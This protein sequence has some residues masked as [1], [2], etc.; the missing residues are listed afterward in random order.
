MGNTVFLL[1]AEDPREGVVGFETWKD[2]HALLKLVLLK[3]E[4][5]A[6]LCVRPTTLVALLAAVSPTSDAQVQ[7]IE[8]S[9]L[10]PQQQQEAAGPELV[11]EGELPSFVKDLLETAD[12]KSDECQICFETNVEAVYFASCLHQVCR[13]CSQRLPACPFC[14]KRVVAVL[15][16]REF[17]AKY[18]PAAPVTAGIAEKDEEGDDVATA[19]A[20]DDKRK[21]IV[22]VLPDQHEAFLK[23]RCRQT[24]AAQVGRLAP[25]DE[26]FLNDVHAHSPLL[27]IQC[28]LALSE[29]KKLRSEE[30]IAFIAAKSSSS[31]SELSKLLPLYQ[32]RNGVLRLERLLAAMAGDSGKKYSAKE[33]IK[34]LVSRTEATG[35]EVEHG[36]GSS[37][38]GS[39]RKS[40]T[41]FPRFL[42]RFIMNA[43]SCI[44]EQKAMDHLRA[45][46][47]DF[48]KPILL[49]RCHPFA[50]AAKLDGP[51]KQ[52]LLT[53][54]AL[55]ARNSAQ[56][57]ERW[58]KEAAQPER[59]GAPRPQTLVLP[60]QQFSSSL[61]RFMGYLEKQDAAI[62]GFL[63]NGNHGLVA[64][65]LLLLLRTFPTY[66]H[67][68]S[69]GS[70]RAHPAF[71]PEMLRR[72]D[73]VTIMELCHCINVEMERLRDVPGDVAETESVDQIYLTSS[74]VM[75]KGKKVLPPGSEVYTR[76]LRHTL[77]LLIARTR[78]L[79]QTQKHPNLQ[80]LVLD[81]RDEALVRTMVPRG[82]QFS[83][84]T[85][86][87]HA[88]ANDSSF[89]V[90]PE[91]PLVLGTYWI[92]EDVDIDL[93]SVSLDTDFNVIGFCSYSQPRADGEV[94]H[95][96][97]VVHPDLQLGSE[98][99]SERI[100]I[101]SLAKW[102][103]STG[104]R[105]IV[106]V[107]FSFSGVP[108]DEVKECLTFFGYNDGGGD[109]P[110]KAR[111]LACR[112]LR[113]ASK[114]NISLI[115]D[116]EKN[117][118]YLCNLNVKHK[119][120]KNVEGLKK[121]G[122][123]GELVRSY[124]QYLQQRP[125]LNYSHVV[126]FLPFVYNRVL[127][128]SGPFDDPSDLYFEKKP[129]QTTE[130][131]YRSL[132]RRKNGQPL[133]KAP[134]WVR[135]VLTGGE[136]LPAQPNQQASRDPPGSLHAGVSD[137]KTAVLAATPFM[138]L[139]LRSS[140]RPHN[141]TYSH[142]DAKDK[143]GGPCMWIGNKPPQTGLPPGSI[144]ASPFITDDSLLN[145]EVL[146]CL[147][148]KEL[149]EPV[150]SKAETAPD[151]ESSSKAKTTPDKE[152]SSK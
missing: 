97:D 92:S 116:A 36:H 54:A 49:H 147:C 107:N 134:D 144:V 29:E 88:Q 102:A 152:S 132:R 48:W 66:P 8:N 150:T 74:R 105:Y 99:A 141:E 26:A 94:K 82:K 42:Q 145:V 126:S 19:R 61:G 87:G 136:K 24:I 30:V 44:P 72:W 143:G 73:I 151:K 58:S 130:S 128:R 83:V 100:W 140:S 75:H 41:A 76:L 115:V 122:L 67:W 6:Y 18:A 81:N 149:A 84:P 104:G 37:P 9:I 133:H 63:L 85:W 50:Y 59:K 28:L 20:R 12:A 101:P 79:L 142:D 114:I 31:A 34:S 64:R 14:R 7:L 32:T 138:P 95:S 27:L 106:L 21:K 65:R 111:V 39:E 57:Q 103:Q 80:L 23:Q 117:V 90:D 108:F 89:L 70:D 35:A 25:K 60:S 46:K 77:K 119:T 51:P 68:F 137:T 123:L 38:Q 1:H 78:A 98:H 125:P 53:I 131:F 2:I 86:A 40:R 16:R 55:L 96:G 11:F 148:P 62:F 10:P 118:A 135:G 5:V 91:L 129:E 113:G 15:T 110:E 47:E 121:E 93:S 112:R 146:R 139:G 3:K 124:F 71:L 33:L 45:R 17:V 4:H 120:I 43:L 69:S 22:L 56:K 127:I 109:G 52:Q 13:V